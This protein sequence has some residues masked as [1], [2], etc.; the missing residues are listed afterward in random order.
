MSLDDEGYAALIGLPIIVAWLS[1]PAFAA[2]FFVKAARTRQGQWTFLAVQYAIF[3][4]MA[5]A[6][7]DAYFI[8]EDPKAPFGLVAFAFYQYCALPVLAFLASLAGWRARDG[9]R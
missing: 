1:G 9:W 4:S 2:C 7:V 3:V 8:S 5:A 6:A